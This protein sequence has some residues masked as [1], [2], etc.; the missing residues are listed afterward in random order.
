[1]T[2]FNIV[3][4]GTMIL[5]GLNVWQS[6]GVIAAGNLF[7]VLAG[8]V[9]IS[10]PAAGSP[11]EVITRTMFG[12]RGNRIVNLTAGWLIGVSY[13]AINL[14][15]GALAGFALVQNFGA[16]LNVPLKVAVI[17]IIAV[18]T[19]TISVFGHATIAK[20]SGWFTWILSACII[21]LAVFIFQHANFSYQT[22]VKLATHG[23]A[24]WAVAAV[25]FT[26]I[27]AS[28]MSWGSSADF[29]RYLPRNASKR[30]IV[31]WTA[32]G[33]YLP[34]VAL[35]ALGVFAGTVVDMSDP[36]SSLQA[37]LPQWFY[38]VFLLVVII[39]SITNNVLT[40]YST[41]LALQAAGIPWQ[42]SVTVIFDAIIALAITC[43]ALFI[44]N[45]F[46][47]LNSILELTVPV[48]GPVLGVYIIDI[49]L[50]RNAYDGHELHDDARGGAMWFSRGFNRAG[51]G[52]LVIGAT[53]ALACADTTVFVGP[54]AT[55]LG[56]ADFS[57]LVG[58][59]VGAA[60]YF[61]LSRTRFR[62]DRAL[63]HGAT[64]R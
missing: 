63:E 14:S 59:I 6:L 3:L 39:G 45:F 42:R 51:I 31:A 2:Y 33:G 53:V 46:T 8:F 24:L 55:L 37:L 43:Y 15:V 18:V 62:A 41:G 9:S 29:S 38:P 28:P 54:I 58:P 61:A 57:A 34:S 52:A 16:Q 36:Q 19:F 30:G 47:S 64:S 17:L 21:V 32:L 20:L 22:P 40:A 25:G 35:G 27:A 44:S 50:R 56:G 5:L 26:I 60:V 11:S 23:W 4:G 1:M 13:E 48:L 10:G 12:I 49:I 7:W